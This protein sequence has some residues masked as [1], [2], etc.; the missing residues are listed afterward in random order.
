MDV[1]K[2]QEKYLTLYAKRFPLAYSA[3]V[4]CYTCITS[5]TPSI[6]VCIKPIANATK[7]GYAI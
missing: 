6:R 3:E 2:I 5:I 7:A 4:V 1:V